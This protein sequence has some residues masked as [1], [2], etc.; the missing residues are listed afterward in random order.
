MFK[1]IIEQFK[2]G[3]NDG[4]KDATKIKNYKKKLKKDRELKYNKDK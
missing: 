4:V 2:A 3:L 1:K